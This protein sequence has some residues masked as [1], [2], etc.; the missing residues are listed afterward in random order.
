MPLPF[1]FIKE[2]SNG[3]RNKKRLFRFPSGIDL[4]IELKKGNYDNPTKAVE[5]FI[6]RIQDWCK[7]YLLFNY[8]LK[9]KI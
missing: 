4:D 5:I 9:K 6:K 2:A 7:D 1:I 3:I 8:I